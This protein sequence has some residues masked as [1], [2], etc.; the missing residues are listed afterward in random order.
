MDQQ[1]ESAMSKVSGI[2]RGS[3]IERKEDI[4]ILIW[5]IL[6]KLLEMIRVDT[7]IDMI[8]TEFQ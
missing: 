4:Q 5:V 7:S 1:A 3:F 6:V 8:Y 2:I